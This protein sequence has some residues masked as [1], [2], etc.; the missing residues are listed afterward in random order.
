ME[1]PSDRVRFANFELIPSERRLMRNGRAVDVAPKVFDT[2]LV[3]VRANGRVVS[4]R[5]LTE[6]VWP[7]TYVVENSLT[8]NISTLRRLLGDAMI[9]T[10]PKFGYRLSL[11]APAASAP[12]KRKWLSASIVA[13]ALVTGLAGGFGRTDTDG[14]RS[15]VVEPLRVLRATAAQRYLADAVPAAIVTRLSA[16]RGIVIRTGSNETVDKIIRGTF[17]ADDLTVQVF[18]E[19]VDAHRGVIEWSHSYSSAPEEAINLEERVAQDVSGRLAP[20]LTDAQRA[21]LTPARSSSGAARAEYFRGRD[22]IDRRTN[23]ADAIRHFESAIDLDPGFALAWAGLAEACAVAPLS[24]S[25][26]G[27]ERAEWAARRAIALDP[28]TAEA[29]A[30]LGFIDLFHRWRWAEAERELRTALRLNPRSARVHDWLAIALL[31]L[32]RT[33]EA[34]AEVDRAYALDPTSNDIPNDVVLVHYFAR[35]FEGA[36]RFARGAMADSP[37]R[38]EA[39]RAYVIEPLMQLGH[40]D[41]A[42]AEHSKLLPVGEEP[43]V[44]ATLR[45]RHGERGAREQILALLRDPQQLK[46]AGNSDA[47]AKIYAMIDDKQAAMQWLDRAYAQHDFGLIFAGVDPNWDSL[48]DE[49]K[50]Q[51]LLHRLQITPAAFATSS[52]LH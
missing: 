28:S 23:F 37:Q 19:I 49:R 20:S 40:Y 29:H 21:A 32:G 44:R 15:V 13:A 4:K 14:T 6:A 16:Q 11:P 45:Y 5:E 36:I 33:A 52:N 26:G 50:F 48:R 31:P 25:G 43:L 51:D 35:D 39:M 46:R 1:S 17:Q 18:V 27:I 22:L 10:V 8:K 2:L 12:A 30:A 3:L 24:S 9:E 38:S 47:I 42:L 7:D 34:C 41:E